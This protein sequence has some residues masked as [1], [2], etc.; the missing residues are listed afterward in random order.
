MQVYRAINN[1]LDQRSLWNLERVSEPRQSDG[2]EVFFVAYTCFNLDLEIFTEIRPNR[3]L[4]KTL[5]SM[6]N[7]LYFEVKSLR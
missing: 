2:L 1:Y 6:M 4:L 7:L 3:S 5:R